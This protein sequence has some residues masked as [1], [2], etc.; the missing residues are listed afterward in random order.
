MRAKITKPFTIA[1]EGYRVVTFQIGDIVEGYIAEK[2][3]RNHYACAM[4][5]ERETKVVAVTER[6]R[7]AK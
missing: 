4:F 1:L 6:K 2:A 7:R 3:L 5:P